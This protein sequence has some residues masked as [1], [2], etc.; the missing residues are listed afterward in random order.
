ML[1]EGYRKEVNTAGPSR[2]QTS[3]WYKFYSMLETSLPKQPRHPRAPQSRLEHTDQLSSS[4]KHNA[5]LHL[6]RRPLGH[7]CRLSAGRCSNA[8]RWCWNGRRSTSHQGTSQNFP[9]SQYAANILQHWDR[10]GESPV[11]CP[12]AGAKVAK[13]R[14]PKPISWDGMLI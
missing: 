8:C 3:S 11:I 9:I 2:A 1:R 10:D 4:I 7:D 12:I 13:V 14:H 5:R 6:C